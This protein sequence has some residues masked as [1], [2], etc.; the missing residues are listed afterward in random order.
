LARWPPQPHRS[1]T[2]RIVPKIPPRAWTLTSGAQKPALP[3]P[4]GRASTPIRAFRDRPV[5]PLR[6]PFC[7]IRGGRGTADGTPATAL[8]QPLTPGERGAIRR[9][10]PYITTE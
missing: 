9:P 3:V 10:P 2:L 5:R 6:H 4:A 7:S 8:A 1:P